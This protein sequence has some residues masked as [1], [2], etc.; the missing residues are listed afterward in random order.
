MRV[1]MY[2]SVSG[3][4]LNY[5]LKVCPGVTGGLLAYSWYYVYLCRVKR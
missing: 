2:L 5:G 3:V 1:K 4:F